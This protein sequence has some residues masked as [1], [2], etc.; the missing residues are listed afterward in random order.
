MRQHAWNAWKQ[1]A[2]GENIGRTWKEMKDLVSWK[3]VDIGLIIL[4]Q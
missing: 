4:R 1:A 2:I 3:S